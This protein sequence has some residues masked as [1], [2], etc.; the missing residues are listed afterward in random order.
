MSNTLLCSGLAE[1]GLSNYHACFSTPSK[2]L[3][4][5]PTAA[6]SLLTATSHHSVKVITVC[7]ERYH[8]C[9]LSLS[10]SRK[11]AWFTRYV[12]LKL[13][14]QTCNASLISVCTLHSVKVCNSFLCSVVRYILVHFPCFQYIFDP[15]AA[16]NKLLALH[17]WAN[18]HKTTSVALHTCA[19]KWPT[20]GRFIVID[21]GRSHDEIAL[22]WWYSV[23]LMY[24]MN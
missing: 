12:K 15:P 8:L 24:S 11:H 14:A 5:K 22:Y 7:C 13:A 17:K 2:I 3:N 18:Q 4:H 20:R 16:C 10:D 21:S 1:L 6:P 19:S 9:L 23:N